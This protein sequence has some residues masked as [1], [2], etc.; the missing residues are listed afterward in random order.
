MS[1]SMFSFNT[2][3]NGYKDYRTDNSYHIKHGIPI[4]KH[5]KKRHVSLSYMSQVVA[6]AKKCVDP[7]KYNRQTDWKL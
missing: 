6:R 2:I 7:R 3:D 4:G 5:P 1:M